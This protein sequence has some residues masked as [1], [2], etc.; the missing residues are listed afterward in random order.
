MLY[1][2]CLLSGGNVF[3]I[4]EEKWG[5]AGVTMLPN[6]TNPPPYTLDGYIGS[7]LGIYL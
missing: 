6:P 5:V 3:S 1:R 7:I 2:I 4:E